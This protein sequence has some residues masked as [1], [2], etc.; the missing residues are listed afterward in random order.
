M[1]SAPLI[2]GK[3]FFTEFG[4]TMATA[5]RPMNP[6]LGSERVYF[7]DN[8]FGS[9]RTCRVLL[10]RG[11]FLVLNMKKTLKGFPKVAL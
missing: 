1:E 10:E 4:E 9:I 6:F 7:G 5:L 2:K 11:V 8:S 3:E